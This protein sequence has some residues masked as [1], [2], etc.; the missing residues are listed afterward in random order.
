[1]PVSVISV[2]QMRD[3]ENASWAAGISSDAVIQNVGKLIAKRMLELTRSGDSIILLAGRGHNGDDAR[4]AL[5]HLADRHA[6]LINVT[7]PA[8]ATETLGRL[9]ETMETD[10]RTWIVDGLFGIGLNRQLSDDWIGLINTINATDLPVLAVDSPSGLNVESGEPAGAA[11]RAVV[12]LTVGA[13]KAGLLTDKAKPYV[14]RLEVASQI[15]LVEH[16]LISDLYWTVAEDFANFPPRRPVE[17]HKGTYGHLAIFAGSMGCHGASVLATQ[18]AQ[19]AQPGLITIWTQPSVYVPVAAHL[20]AAMVHSWKPAQSLPKSISGFLIGPGLADDDLTDEFK[21]EMRALWL[22][23]PLPVVVDASALDWIPS[24]PVPSHAIR[25]IT[26]HPG[27][28]ARMIGVPTEHLQA[29][30]PGCLRALSRRFGDCWVVLKGHQTLVGKASGNIFVNSS[31]N[32][33][34]AQGGSGD[35]LAG[36]MGGLLA[37]PQLQ[38]HALRSIRFAVWEHGAAADRLSASIPNWTPEELVRELGR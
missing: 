12:T 35:I 4:A 15:G 11:I 21:N 14:G 29:D 17:S 31:G 30:R 9:V 24:G 25:V 38:A 16:L 37:Q 7:D 36:Y 20:R 13:V 33:F 3:W 34:L 6:T 23:T 1:M 26:P 28:A 5:P 19:R 10:R 32:P 22:E 27:E 18:G 2:A 8:L